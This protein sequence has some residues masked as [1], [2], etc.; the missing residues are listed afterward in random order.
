LSSFSFTDDSKQQFSEMLMY[1]D[2]LDPPMEEE[3]GQITVSRYDDDEL[4]RKTTLV[5]KPFISDVT[6]VQSSDISDVFLTAK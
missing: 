5:D 1:S 3:E 6:D 2:T 4:S